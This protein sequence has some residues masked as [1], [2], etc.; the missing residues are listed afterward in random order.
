MHLYQQSSN[1]FFDLPPYCLFWRKKQAFGQLL[2]DGA[3][4]LLYIQSSVI[5]HNIEQQCAS[6][7]RK[8][9]LPGSKQQKLETMGGMGGGATGT[10]YAR[11][12]VKLKIRHRI[13]ALIGE[14]LLSGT[15]L[16]GNNLGG[17]VF[18]WILMVLF[19]DFFATTSI[20]FFNISL[21][22]ENYWSG[23]SIVPIIAL[24]Y[25]FH[26]SFVLQEAEPFLTKKVYKISYPI[27]LLK[28]LYEFNA[29]YQN[30]CISYKF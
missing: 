11:L 30:N 22:N 29:F 24:A 27:I 7:R 1:S 3:S 25:I 5:S 26:A 15:M 13:A 14:Q 28:Y 12:S 20:P 6:S 16:G 4:S 9:G 23:L 8:K 10:P 2:S 17:L 18:F 21:I 19:V